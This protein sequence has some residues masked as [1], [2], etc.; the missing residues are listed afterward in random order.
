VI[1]AFSIATALASGFA[2]W[3]WFKSSLQDPKIVEETQASISDAQELHI[4]DAKVGIG[5]FFLSSWSE[6]KEKTHSQADEGE[7]GRRWW[8]AGA[9]GAPSDK[10]VLLFGA[11]AALA[12]TAEKG[13]L[14]GPSTGAARSGQRARVAPPRFNL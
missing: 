8:K 2:A 7:R 5:A 14:S 10:R 11:Q 3:F 1:T 4:L 6:A 9:V 13:P 12:R